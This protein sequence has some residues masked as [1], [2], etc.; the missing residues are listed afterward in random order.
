MKATNELVM[1]REIA[2]IR[3]LKL[4]LAQV[5]LSEAQTRLNAAQERVN[6]AERRCSE[7]T[8]GLQQAMSADRGISL[9]KFVNWSAAIAASHGLQE[10]CRAAM[11]QTEQVQRQ[12]H[13]ELSQANQVAESANEAVKRMSRRV[14]LDAEARLAMAN[15]DL[16]A[17]RLERA[18]E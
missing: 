14:H 11:R 17:M 12:R 4:E 13:D 8:I 15:E 6:V 5:S 18:Y 10:E 2:A 3:N 16:I 9:D 1:L 7:Q